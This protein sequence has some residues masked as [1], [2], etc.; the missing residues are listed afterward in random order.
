MSFIVIYLIFK[1]ISN[2]FK[3]KDEETYDTSLENKERKEIQ[4]ADPLTEVV[5]IFEYLQISDQALMQSMPKIKINY[6]DEYR[7]VNKSVSLKLPPKFNLH[8]GVPYLGSEAF[9]LDESYSL[10][11][12]FIYKMQFH[13]KTFVFSKP[14]VIVSKIG[15]IQSK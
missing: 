4:N 14:R 12:G 13:P 2:R 11:A 3:K 6:Q 15:K 7:L 10:D 8:F 1:A 9:K 5:V